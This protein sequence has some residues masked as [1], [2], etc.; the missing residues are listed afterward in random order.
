MSKSYS[1]F[2]DYLQDVYY[3]EIFKAIKDYIWKKG[4]SSF[5]SYAVMDVRYLQLDDIHVKTVNTHLTDGDLIEFVAAV[6]ADIILKGI[7][8]RDYDADSTSQWYSV[9]FIGHLF[10]GLNMVTIKG[11]DDYRVDRFDKETSLSKYMVPYLYA[12]NLEKEAEV[13]LKKY[14]PK[15]LKEP[16][17]IPIDDILMNLAL[18]FHFAPLSSNVFGMTYFRE[19]DVD[20]I[21]SETGQVIPEQH[22]EPGTIL[23]N[24]DAFFMRNVGSLNNTIIHECLHWDRHRKFFELQKLLNTDLRA[25]SCSVTENKNAKRTGLNGALQ[26]MEWQCNALTPRILMP[27]ETTRSKLNQILVELNKEW[28]DVSDSERMEEAINRLADFFKV[29]KIAAKLRAV[30]LGFTT[31]IGVYN[32]VGGS[33]L[34][35]FSFNPQALNKDETFIISDQNATFEACV[36][37]ISKAK[38]ESGAYVYVDHVF[39]I[40]DDLY[41][42]Q[43]ENGDMALTDYARQHMDECCLKFKNNFKTGETNGDAYYTQC[44]LCRN[45]ASEVFNEANYVDDVQNASVSG[46]AEKAKKRRIE[47]R[48]IIS[49]LQS[50]SP[51]FS[52]TLKYH[53]DNYE[54]K[55]IKQGEL[56]ESEYG[57]RTNYSERQIRSFLTDESIQKPIRATCALCVGL[58][59]IPDFSDDLVEKSGHRWMMTEEE[60]HYKRFLHYQ[61][62]NSL[63]KINEQ[64]VA[65]GCKPWGG[66][67]TGE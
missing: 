12:E 1:S 23:I 9:S 66:R 32:F 62:K 61:Y 34:P 50:L 36:D 63:S 46:R 14:C 67:L 19:A 25:L 28:P 4:R 48:Y 45:I 65:L 35:S 20:L 49:I 51:M 57:T 33:Y 31:A 39:C 3:D 18:E 54:D 53:F 16:M 17:P 40:D 29:S 59:L 11:V 43:D 6:E 56:T 41:I 30:D 55:N 52:K 2:S 24:P 44:A 21:D 42:T 27:K 13:F 60:L 37:P 58:H 22:I 26:W 47:A 38:L 5:S 64:L 15:A 8:R 10:N 7:G